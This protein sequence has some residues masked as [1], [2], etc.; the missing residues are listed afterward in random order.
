M[1][2]TPQDY[3]THGRP[4]AAPSTEDSPLELDSDAWDEEDSLSGPDIA[5]PPRS[6]WWLL[7]I[8]GLLTLLAAAALV[9]RSR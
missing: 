6:P 8:V 7:A 1:D 9:W 4:G 5:P 3:D 2:E